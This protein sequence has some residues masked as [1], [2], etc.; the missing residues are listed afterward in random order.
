MSEG[1]IQGSYAAEDVTFLLKPVALAPLAV[2]EKERR[3]QSGEAHYSEMISEERRPD[4][5]YMA[6]YRQALARHAVRIGRE[7]AAVAEQLR[8]RIALGVLPGEVTLC[9][10]V[11]AGI[12]YGVL[13]HRALCHLGIDSRHYGVSIIRDRGLDTVAMAH[14]CQTRDPAGVLFVDGWTG[15]GAIAGELH[16]AWQGMQGAEPTLVVLADPSGHASVSGSF[17]DWLI[18]S[19]ILGANV[20]GLISR[21]ILNA[22]V[23]GPGDYH[24]AIPVQH[25]ADLD[26]SR[27]FVDAVFAHVRQQL[28]AGSAAARAP[29]DRAAW[30][31][32]QAA[33]QA[34]R[35]QLRAQAAG[36]VTAI[37]ERFAVT[38]PNRIKP[39]IAEATRAVLRRK[40]RRVFLRDAADPDLAALIHLCRQDGVAMEVDAAAT[41]PFRAITLIER[42]S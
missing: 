26:Q 34:T 5:R 29:V 16:R 24:G 36:C 23:I 11:R 7:I 12:P 19:G 38:N 1:C 15:K 20:S 14:V 2:D 18:P 30:E 4:D 27:A 21:S 3:I 13:L 31:Q 17:E 9:S 6:I 32:Q 25:L 40:P 35:A 8:Q 33:D 39:G 22:A 37:M 28:P 10:L 42:V 41:G